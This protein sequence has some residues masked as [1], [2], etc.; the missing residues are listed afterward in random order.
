MKKR[1]LLGLIAVLF[2]LLAQSGIFGDSAEIRAVSKGLTVSLNNQPLSLAKEYS[3]NS[4]QSATVAEST[5]GNTIVTRVID[6]DTLWVLVNEKTEK[7]RLIGVD[8]PET[9]DPRKPVQCFGKEASDF[10]KALLLNKQIILEADLS[11]GDRDKYGRLLR[12]V[13]LNDGTLVNQKIIADGYGHEYTYRIPYK[14]Q[15]EFKTAEQFA[16]T[17]EQGLWAPNACVSS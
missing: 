14:Y 4:S 17:R 2:V 5:T 15:T 13:F 8:T 9:V 1:I 12:Y 7:V 16:R 11:Q 6:G 10:T 3:K